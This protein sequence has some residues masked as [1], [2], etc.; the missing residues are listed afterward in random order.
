MDCFLLI[1]LIIFGNIKPF[2]HAGWWQLSQPER[3]CCA[4]FRAKKDCEYQAVTKKEYLKNKKTSLDSFGKY[5]DSTREFII[6]SH[7]LS[8][9]GANFKMVILKVHIFQNTCSALKLNNL[10]TSDGKILPNFWT[11]LPRES[12]LNRSTQSWWSPWST[13]WQ[14]WV[15]LLLGRSKNLPPLVR[16]CGERCDCHR[17]WDGGRLSIG[18]RAHEGLA[19]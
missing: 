11:Q 14:G 10:K 4:A 17:R 16:P 7:K 8:W 6:N 1:F 9:N 5:L 3:N 13:L 19:F 12:K 18:C 15:S 2:V